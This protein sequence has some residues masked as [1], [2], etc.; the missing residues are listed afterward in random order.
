MTPFRVEFIRFNRDGE[1]AL[2]V[3]RELRAE[4][5]FDAEREA[6]RVRDEADAPMAVQFDAAFLRCEGSRLRRYGRNAEGVAR[7]GRA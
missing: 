6:L 4:T 1:E 7:W 5:M 3:R 2:V